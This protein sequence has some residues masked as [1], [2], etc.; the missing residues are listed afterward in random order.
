MTCVK[1]TQYVDGVQSGE[2]T[3]AG[4]FDTLDAA[5]TFLFVKA[6]SASANGYAVSDLTLDSFRAVKGAKVRLFTVED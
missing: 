1:W 2:P 3:V 5:R 4:Q 6:E